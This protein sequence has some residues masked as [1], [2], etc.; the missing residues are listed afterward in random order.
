VIIFEVKGRPKLI[1]RDL[2]Q[3]LFQNDFFRGT[4]SRNAT[5]V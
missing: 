1:A 2:N 3:Q 4:Q 5:K